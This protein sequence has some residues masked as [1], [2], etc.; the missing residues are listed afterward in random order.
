M[1]DQRTKEKIF[2]LYAKSPN[3]VV[4]HPV[5]V[6]VGPVPIQLDNRRAFSNP[7]LMDLLADTLKNLIDWKGI[8]I[9][10]GAETAGMPLAAILSHKTR[11][12]FNY[13]RKKM[14][15]TGDDHFISGGANPGDKAILIDD[16]MAKGGSK[17]L[18]IENMK[19]DG[20]ETVALAMIFKTMAKFFQ[21]NEDRK[22]LESGG[23]PIY[24]LFAWEELIEG[25]YKRGIIDEEIFPYF[26]DYAKHPETWSKNASKWDTY[27]EVLKKLN[28]PIPQEVIEAVDEM[29][30]NREL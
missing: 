22:E 7:D 5:K 25:L 19:H 4:K 23:M 24:C 13:I 29:R 6:T 28:Y 21:E 27:F 1:I 26:I 3:I 14:R 11:V 18:F 9:I 15:G 20:V 16:L 12:P 17:K 2:D 30:R 10:M 8:D